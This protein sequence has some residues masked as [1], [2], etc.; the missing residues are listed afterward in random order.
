MKAKIYTFPEV[1]EGLGS[2]KSN[3]NTETMLKI[4]ER[5]LERAEAC[6][7]GQKVDEKWK[8]N[9]RYDFNALKRIRQQIAAEDGVKA[10][11]GEIF[12]A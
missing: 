3:A 5:V 1:A 12:N 11:W 9:G 2:T 7:I 8:F 4:V 6:G 10:G